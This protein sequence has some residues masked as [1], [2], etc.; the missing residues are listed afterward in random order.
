MQL[1]CIQFGLFSEFAIIILIITNIGGSDYESIDMVVNITTIPDL[2][3][4]PIALLEDP[5]IENRE[6]FD[7]VINSDDPAVSIDR[8]RSRIFIEDSTSRLLHV[9][10][11]LLLLHIIYLYHC[12]CHY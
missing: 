9:L 4:F 6:R 11:C 3:C 7:V 2:M 10:K 8:V 12:S 5:V 1:V